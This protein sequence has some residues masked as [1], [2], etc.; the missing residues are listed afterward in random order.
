MVS[1]KRGS[2]FDA[3]RVLGVLDGFV[4]MGSRRDDDRR[5]VGRA[6]GVQRQNGRSI[7]VRYYGSDWSVLAGIPGVSG[8][9]RVQ[10]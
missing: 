3:S 4:R 9:M 7:L 2:I 10:N 1:T 6:D 5:R 8:L